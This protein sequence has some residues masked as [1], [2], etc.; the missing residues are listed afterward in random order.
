MTAPLSVIIP[1]LNTADTLP[2]TAAALLEGVQRDLVCEL[3]ICDGGSEDRTLALADAL[4]AVIVTSPPGRG[5]QLRAGA[6]AARG[7]WRL[8]LHADSIL[9]RGW[10]DAVLHHIKAGPEQAGYFD[11]RF[12]AQGWI[13]AWFAAWANLRSRLLS[14]PYGDQGLL[15][16]RDLYDRVGGYPAIPLMEDVALS[17]KLRGTLGSLGCH[18]ATG[19]DSYGDRGWLV[20]GCRN[21]GLLTL[22]FLGVSPDRLAGW[23]TA[24]QRS[25]T[26]PTPG[27]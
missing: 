3:I 2:A 5:Q 26:A 23:Y 20:G 22:Y 11:L 17:R 12:T 19:T 25:N 4:G 16:H 7:A 24:G 14:L 27:T 8:F 9:D 21:L 18:A 10:S 6:A 13:P 1:T 15:I